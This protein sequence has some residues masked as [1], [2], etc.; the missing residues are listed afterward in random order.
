MINFSKFTTVKIDE[1]SWRFAERSF[2]LNFLQIY[3]LTD[4]HTFFVKNINEN[5]IGRIL[6]KEWYG[7]SSERNFRMNQLNYKY[8]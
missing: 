7:S 3:L 5:K 1:R 4:A 6:S 2:K 8:K